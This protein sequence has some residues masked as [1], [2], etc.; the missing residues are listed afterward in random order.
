[1]AKFDC[2][3][4]VDLDLKLDLERGIVRDSA[5]KFSH[6]VVLDLNVD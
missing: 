2:H 1:M 6:G 3:G 4:W 5:A